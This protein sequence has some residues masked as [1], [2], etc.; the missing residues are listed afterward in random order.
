MVGAGF[1]FG[2]SFWVTRALRQALSRYAPD[3]LALSLAE[4][5]RELSA[6]L[7]AR[8][9]DPTD[10]PGRAGGGVASVTAIARGHLARAGGD[11]GRREQAR[12][13]G[14]HQGRAHQAG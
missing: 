9:A 1:G 6:A 12:A 10:P 4:Q 2:V 11:G 3:R 7:R 14:A 8:L 13:G 5:V